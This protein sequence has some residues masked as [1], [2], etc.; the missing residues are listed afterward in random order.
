MNSV[1]ESY[2]HNTDYPHPRERKS[3]SHYQQRNPFKIKSAVSLNENGQILD[4]YTKRD[5]NGN[6]TQY[7]FEPEFRKGFEWVSDPDTKAYELVFGFKMFGYFN[8]ESN[9]FEVKSQYDKNLDVISDSHLIEAFQVSHT[10]GILQSVKNY[11]LYGNPK[12]NFN[13][14]QIGLVP[15]INYYGY[16]LNN[17]D[18]I[19][20]I[21]LPFCY[22]MSNYEYSQYQSGPRTIKSISQWLEEDLNS[23]LMQDLTRKSRNLGYSSIEPSN[24]YI[25][26]GLM[27]YNKRL[28]TFA[29]ILTSY[30]TWSVNYPDNIA[31][32]WEN[33]IDDLFSS[34]SNN[35][36]EELI[37]NEKELYQPNIH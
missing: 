30:F 34:E 13:L 27:F 14:S 37:P 8:Y 22:I 7:K 35:S 36:S 24:R 25:P 32:Y 5:K 17:K 33:S 29:K 16:H 3:V 26:Y 11:N 23:K 18:N 15:N 10:L 21:F 20:N 9:R 1:Q 12:T 2:L 19:T 4:F 6:I 31:P 28:N